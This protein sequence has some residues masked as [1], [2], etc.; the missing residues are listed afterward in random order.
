VGHDIAVIC[1]SVWVSATQSTEK[2]MTNGPAS[3]LDKA[4]QPTDNP[5]RG[6]S[7]AEFGRQVP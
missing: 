6:L 1:I 5:L 4:L 2:K 7:V 3:L